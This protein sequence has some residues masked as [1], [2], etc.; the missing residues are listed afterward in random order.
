MV[1]VHAV[2]ELYKHTKTDQFDHLA[3]DR[4]VSLVISAEP[5]G[6]KQCEVD[7]KFFY[8]G[9][10]AGDIKQ[11]K[12]SRHNKQ[13]LY[14]Q[15]L[16]GVYSSVDCD[17]ATAGS[18]RKLVCTDAGIVLRYCTLFFEVKT[19]HA[20][21]IMP[22]S[23]PWDFDDHHDCLLFNPL[24]MEFYSCTRKSWVKVNKASQEHMDAQV[25]GAMAWEGLTYAGRNCT[26]RELLQHVRVGTLGVQAMTTYLDI[27][28]ALG[29]PL[30]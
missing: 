1:Q 6:I 28:G 25:E 27:A 9:A 17:V 3:G 7:A 4:S 23:D 20:I 26:V 10:D 8:G 19:E 21:S 14:D 22:A 11:L 16:H 15:A 18:L 29:A 24:I 30:G 12:V 5:R 2:V 13:Q